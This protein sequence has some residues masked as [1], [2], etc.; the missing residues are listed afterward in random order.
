VSLRIRGVDPLNHHE[1]GWLIVSG[2]HFSKN[3]WQVEPANPR[4]PLVSGFLTF[5]VIWRLD[6]GWRG[7]WQEKPANHFAYVFIAY[8]SLSLYIYICFLK[9]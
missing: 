3:G 1:I 2:Y 9:K 7:G 8:G 5:Y 4:Q 6:G